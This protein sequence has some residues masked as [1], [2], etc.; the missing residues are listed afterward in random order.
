MKEPQPEVYNTKKV[1]L[2]TDHHICYNPRLWKE[3]FFYEKQ[4]YEVVILSM[5]Q[6]KPALQKDYELLSGHGITYK[7]FLN[8][9]PGSINNFARLFFRARK[10]LA[11]YAQ[12]YLKT[13]TRWAISHSPDLMFKKA[14]A[15]NADLYS[16]HLECAFYAG[17]S[18]IKAGKKV[19]FDFEDWYSRDY[20][21]PER[22]I[23]LLESLEKFALHN[24]IFCTAASR[25]MAGALQRKYTT[26]EELTVIYNGFSI[27]D[28][29]FTTI[30]NRERKD[31]EGFSLLWFSRTVGP[32]RGIEKLLLAMPYCEVAVNLHLLGSMAPGYSDTLEQEFM[33]IPR[34]QLKMHSFMRHQ[35]LPQ[36]I[37][38]FQTG[39]AIEENINDSRSL[40]VTNKILQ[41]LQAGLH[42]IAS[43]TKGQAEVAELFP[44]RVSIVDINDPKQFAAAIDAARETRYTLTPQDTEKIDAVFSW[45]AQE[46]K[47]KQLIAKTL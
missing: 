36:F 21:V 4:G 30:A 15:E 34:H 7:A 5:W 43:D 41:Y 35:L 3:A 42:I 27:N 40:T 11:G 9:V 10:R 13:G 1:C 33:K 38:Q 45:E 47:L 23:S 31:D 19:S 22:P 26:N 18:L 2:L 12:K 16:A 17:R 28:Y 6:S 24:G 32:E 37:S 25:S 20:L 8:L 39:L 14:L 29:N 46:R 44:E